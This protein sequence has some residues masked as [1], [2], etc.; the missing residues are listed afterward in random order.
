MAAASICIGLRAADLLP[1]LHRMEPSPLGFSD[2]LAWGLI[3]YFLIGAI[4]GRI[5]N[6]QYKRFEANTP[7]PFVNG[8]LDG[9]R[10]GRSENEM[11]PTRIDERDAGI[12]NVVHFDAYKKIQSLALWGTILL[13]FSSAKNYPQWLTAPLAFLIFLIVMFLPQTLFLWHEPDME[14]KP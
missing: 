6:F 10:S 7:F 8:F 5:D 12:R 9:I 1:R 11:D 13:L 2:G 3:F 14:N 4:I